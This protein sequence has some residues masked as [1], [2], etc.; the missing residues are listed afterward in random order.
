MDNVE[1]LL[2]PQYELPE[3]VLSFLEIMPPEESRPIYNS[4]ILACV[5]G[6]T[7][8][9]EWEKKVRRNISK[10]WKN[11]KDRNNARERSKR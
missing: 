5:M 9:E 2:E 3:S 7:S 6:D 10:A 8:V 4:F 1:F 11:R